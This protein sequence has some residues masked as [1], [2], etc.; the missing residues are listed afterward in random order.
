MDTLDGRFVSNSPVEVVIPN[1]AASGPLSTVSS[2]PSYQWLDREL[3]FVEQRGL[4]GMLLK[5][6][7]M[8]T[9]QLHVLRHFFFFLWYFA[10]LDSVF[11]R[12]FERLF[13]EDLPE[14]HSASLS[15]SGLNRWCRWV[16]IPVLHAHS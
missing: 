3:R 9:T 15:L 8:P 12:P 14:S 5:Y 11:F 10:L 7:Q 13:T 6:S 4:E 1:S 16:G 2:L